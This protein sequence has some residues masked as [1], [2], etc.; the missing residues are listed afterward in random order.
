MRRL[1]ACFPLALAAACT[2]STIVLDGKGAGVDS[3]ADPG[4]NDTGDRGTDTADT[5]GDSGDTGE[6]DS[7]DPSP[8]CLEYGAIIEDSA[9]LA[10]GGTV[11]GYDG[12]LGAWGSTITEDGSLAVNGS[13]EC[14]V[15]NGATVRGSLYVGGDPARS[16]CEEWGGS[17]TGGV[18]AL[19]AA[20]G[21]P[22]VSEPS[23]LPDEEGE[24]NVAWEE[25]RELSGVHH[26]D[27]A[28][29]AYGGTL[30]ITGPTVI[31]VDSFN[32]QGATITL[33]AGANLDVYSR[34]TVDFAWGTQFNTGGDA[35]A[36]RLL[37]GEEDS[38]TLA[39]GA[40]FTGQ[41]L[42]PRSPMYVSGSV[43]GGV[44][45]DTL[46]LYWGGALHVDRA[47]LCP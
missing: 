46:E 25:T 22:D 24:L 44:A 27:D 34:G 26:F 15:T 36:V 11:D 4:S 40:W 21:M 42:A 7:G 16:Y 17:L 9:K 28:T 20:A 32:V 38:V 45:A 37:M 31:V 19:A 14:A 13:A 12:S 18:H 2:P 47:L 30:R 8:A 1:L 29:L 43:Q 23:G 6:D 35:A 10:Y 5:G 3:G 39:G 33:D 41:L